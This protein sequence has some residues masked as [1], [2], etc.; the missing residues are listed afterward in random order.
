MK[1]LLLL[2]TIVF[3]IGIINSAYAPDKQKFKVFVSVYTKNEDNLEKQ[4]ID[5]H[6]KRELRSLEDVEI[7]KIED[8]WKLRI[9]IIASITKYKNG[10]KSTNIAIAKSIQVRVPKSL[11]KSYNFPL[12]LEPVY[13]EFRPNLSYWTSDD[14]P[15][16]CVLAANQFDKYL[17]EYFRK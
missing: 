5:S 14:L 3:S 17:T 4:I 15:S 11:F 6:I 2:C 12:G 16:W 8:D 10:E 13:D 1:R 9:L 7:V